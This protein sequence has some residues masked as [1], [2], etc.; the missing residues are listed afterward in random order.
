MEPL[1]TE[2]V[3]PIY[4]RSLMQRYGAVF[5][6]DRSNNLRHIYF[7]RRLNRWFGVSAEH[8]AVRV[9]HHSECPCA[10]SK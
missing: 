10:F 4:F 8:G 1:K 9:N 2:V 7:S 5:M 3:D 6:K